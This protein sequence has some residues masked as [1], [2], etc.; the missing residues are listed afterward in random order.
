MD[1]G[2]LI[3]QLHRFT[4]IASRVLCSHRRLTAVL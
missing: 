4:N 2:F 3:E 1:A